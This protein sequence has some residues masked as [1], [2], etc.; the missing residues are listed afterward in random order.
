MTDPGAAVRLF[1][2]GEHDCPYISDRQA[3]NIVVDPGYLNAGVYAELLKLG[4]RRSGD[5]VQ[6]Y[7]P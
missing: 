4:F 6:T 3:R 1:M 5:H 7:R 2:T